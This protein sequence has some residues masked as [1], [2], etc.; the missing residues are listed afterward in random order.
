MQLSN[1][2]AANL[3]GFSFSHNLAPINI[4]AGPNGTGKTAVVDAITLLATGNHPLYGPT[5]PKLFQL[6][7]GAVMSVAG[8]L[9]TK[10]VTRTWTQKGKT[11]GYED[12]GTAAL[13]EGALNLLAADKYLDSND[14]KRLQM[15]FELCQIEFDPAALRAKIMEGATGVE[16]RK[17]LLDCIQPEGP[18]EKENS[19]RWL[20]GAITRTNDELK[21]ANAE[22][23]RLGKTGEGVAQLA[24]GDIAVN[25]G[26]VRQRKQK[27]EQA[28]A[29][30]N[31][32]EGALQQRRADYERHATAHSLWQD[33]I[34]SLT[35]AM[36]GQEGRELGIVEDELFGAKNMRQ[37]VVETYQA[38]RQLF[39]EYQERSGKLTSTKERYAQALK[40]LQEHQAEA[41]KIPEC[42][43]A[44]EACEPLRA[45]VEQ[46]RTDRAALEAESARISA[47][48]GAACAANQDTN[49]NFNSIKDN[50]CCPTCRTAGTV[51]KT[52]LEAA[53]RKANEDFSESYSASKALLEAVNADIAAVRAQ[54]QAAATVLRDKEAAASTAWT[55]AQYHQRQAAAQQNVVSELLQ[56]GRQLNA[57]L[58]AAPPEPNKPD[59]AQFDAVIE[60][61]TAELPLART[62]RELHEAR[63]N[64]P[65]LPAQVTSEEQNELQQRRADLEA[66][67]EDLR[68]QEQT[69]ANQR[70][71]ERTLQQAQDERNN[72]TARATSLK[73][74]K[75]TLVQE[76]DDLV[77]KAFGPLLKTMQ[78]FTAGILPTPVQYHQGELGRF[79][80]M[81]WIPLK[82]FSGTHLAV[83]A[84]GLQAALGSQ[85]PLKLAI[86]DEMGRFDPVNKNQFVDNIERAIGAG[87]IEQFVGIDVDP[88]E[89]QKW[90]QDGINPRL[91]IIQTGGAA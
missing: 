29:E 3:K 17:T 85:S 43:A 50:D 52:T 82:L 38:A 34:K 83:T 42:Q 33:K 18:E 54:E 80:G 5:R 19:Q 49:E 15:V 71:Q 59:L 87:I 45:K 78:I 90:D 2:S 46:I 51:W 16:W 13:P 57:A 67:A 56:E 75:A 11:V 91:N 14:S 37:K 12:E 6:S 81:S 79:A 69:V 72:A 7:S 24:A 60:Q 4:I 26:N 1:I 9:D 27:L 89:Y 44:L 58:G 30:L 65:Q 55:Q 74:I 63:A 53:L 23:T 47:E 31:Q 88:F 48:I 25:E 62:Q 35:A 61:L 70:A 21:I 32:A 22:V 84:A 68:I 20:E 41:A 36:A 64:E 39:S 86:V 73:E 40:A 8:I 28:L 77:E 66:E 76:R 10:P